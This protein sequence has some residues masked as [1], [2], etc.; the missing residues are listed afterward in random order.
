MTEHSAATFHRSKSLFCALALL[1]GLLT[2]GRGAIP[3]PEKLLPDDTLILATVP[4]FA[5]AQEIWRRT[6]QSQ[7][8]NDPAMRPFK[9]HFLSKW[10]EDLVKPLEQELGIKFEDYAGLLQ[11][12]LTLALIQ[13]GWQGED[14]TPPGVVLLMDSKD[15]SGQ[16]KQ[17]LAEFRKKWVDSGKTSRIEKIHDVDFA[18]FAL[19]T[20]E[21]PK[22]LSKFIPHSSAVQEIGQD[23]QPKKTRAKTEWVVGQVESLLVAGSSPKAVEKVVVRLTGGTVP[24]LGELA[25]YQANHLAMFRDAPVY[26]WVNAK[27]FLDIVLRKAAE[28]K[29]NPDAPNPFDINPAKLINAVGLTSLKTVAFSLQNSEQGALFQAFLGVPENSR[30]G[31]FKILAGEPKD[32]SAPSFVPAEAVKFQR[33]RIDGQKTWAAIERMVSDINPQWLSGINFLLES[34]NTAAKQKDPAFDVKKNLIGNLGDDLIS[35][36][37]AA[38]GDS[39]AELKSPPSIVLLGSPKPEELAVALKSLLVLIGQQAGAAPEEREFLGRKIYSIP[40]R[41]IGLAFGAATAPGAPVTLRYAASGGY[42]ALSTDVSI[43]EE[44]LRSSETQAKTLK[45]TPGL[46]EAAQRV[47]GPGSSLFGFQNQAESIRGWFE[48]VRKDSGAVTNSTAAAAAALWPG[49]HAG[50]KEWVDFSLLPPFEKVSKYFYF[51]VY[52]GSAIVDGLALK[53]F[54]PVPPGA[55]KSQEASKP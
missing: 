42:V 17:R 46:S 21:I 44:F 39:L 25:A 38:R 32:V 47:L 1:P 24:P 2:I 41:S 26:G 51:S 50:L 5:K 22:T 34:A 7:F 10:N 3:A 45:E 49:A 27:A 36:D 13:D 28:K 19:S 16:L 9:E 29:V 33:W 6:P 18:C 11:G 4:D 14:D 20:N 48:L 15:K 12:Q 8:W 31:L 54:S 43:L 40:L 37:K 53:V 55:A 30:Q 23:P 52:G 35:Y